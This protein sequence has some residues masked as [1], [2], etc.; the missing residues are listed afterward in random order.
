MGGWEL[1]QAGVGVSRTWD[2]GRNHAFLHIARIR[3]GLLCQPVV[4]RAAWRVSPRLGVGAV[5]AWEAP[6]PGRTGAGFPASGLSPGPSCGGE[7]VLG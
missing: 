4:D 7:V 6:G 5:R 3:G 2:S 1:D